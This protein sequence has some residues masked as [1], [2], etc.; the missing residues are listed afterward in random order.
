MQRYL[1]HNASS[2]ILPCALKAWQE[3]AVNASGN[4]SSMHW[5]GRQAR[6]VLDDARDVLA[7]YFSVESG[8]VVFTS[9][10]TE[11]NN[12]CL[13]GVLGKRT[14]A[15]CI[16][17]TEHP[18]V[19]NTATALCKQQQRPLVLL[20][21]NQ[22]GQIDPDDVCAQ[23]NAETAMV[24][25]MLANNESGVVNSLADVGAYCRSLG[26][27][28]HVDAV[29]ALGKI[30][31]SFNGVKADF[32]SCS[33]HKV[34]G[35]KGTGALIQRRG[36]LLETWMHGGGQERKRRSGTENIAGAVAFAAALNQCD[37]SACTALRDHFEQVLLTAMPDIVVHGAAATRLPNTSFFS[38][39]NMDGETLLMQLD[40]AGFAVGSGSACSSGKREPSH[41]LRAMGVS[42]P[43]ARSSLRISF[44]AEHTTEDAL[45]LVAALL[46]VRRLLQ[47]MAGIP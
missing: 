37:F 24:S 9:G 6:R 15:M 27:P 38:V 39:P 30:P 10:G 5:A 4:P 29:Q 14:G 32:L 8:A 34:G 33:A 17:S 45:A 22:H 21:V 25:I 47:K 41:V 26:V 31:V 40:L 28:F 20:K 13:A 23:I 19:L 2:P 43:L 42:N 11:A 12:L 36:V 7:D 3:A 18:S 35:A 44:G 1:D 46:R 16:S